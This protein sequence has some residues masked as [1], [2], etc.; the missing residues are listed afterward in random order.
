MPFLLFW[1]LLLPLFA[2]ISGSLFCCL[3]APIFP[4]AALIAEPPARPFFTLIFS[5]LAFCFCCAVAVI[6]VY[7]CASV[8]PDFAFAVVVAA[9]HS[10]TTAVP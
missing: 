4:T 3:A 1:L 6:C 9:G 8:V 7:L 10:R 2:L 5:V